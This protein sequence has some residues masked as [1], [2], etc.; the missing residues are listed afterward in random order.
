MI[1]KC[2]SCGCDIDIPEEERQE[3][4]EFARKEYIANFGKEPD[5]HGAD[6]VICHDCFLI[7]EANE[8][9]E[10]TARGLLPGT[11]KLQ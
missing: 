2:A 8:H 5:V 1:L 9:A 10:L 4:D 11:R 6:C 3:A 7:C